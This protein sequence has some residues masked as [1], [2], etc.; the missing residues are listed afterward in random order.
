MNR[1][2]ALFLGIVLTAFFVG[3]CGAAQAEPAGGSPASSSQQP[4]IMINGSPVSVP[5]GTHVTEG[6]VMVPIRWAAGQLGGGSVDWNA[7]THSIV[8]N[9]NE[10][11]YKVGEYDCYVWGLKPQSSDV[12]LEPLPDRV[13]DLSIPRS[14]GRDRQLVLMLP[15]WQQK[16]AGGFSMG[17]YPGGRPLLNPSVDIMVY[18][19]NQPYPFSDD[20]VYSYENI[21]GH[22]FIPMDWLEELFYTNVIYDKAANRLSIQSPDLMAIDRQIAV[23]R[24]ALTPATP[25]E[26]MQLW[27]LGEQIRNGALQYTVL[28][29]ELSRQADQRIYESGW[30]TGCSSPW[31]G[32]R[33]VKEAKKLGHT[34]V[35]YT[36]SF[37]EITSD[38]TTNGIEKY[39]VSKLIVDGKSGWFIT[40][41]LHSSGYGLL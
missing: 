28:S 13:K 11:L 23:M 39:I 41:M 1:L 10:D 21:N 3:G 36:V 30:I 26:A 9:T 7:K 15:S 34:A 33:T 19:D 6:Q 18:A 17:G 29:P 2:T 12:Q 25:E 24:D 38:G 27:G 4:T 16:Y 8:I 20:A 35:E 14:Y 32:A 37:P 31:V 40:K 22:V 5:P